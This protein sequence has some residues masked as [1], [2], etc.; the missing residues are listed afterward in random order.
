LGL[1]SSSKKNIY[2]FD[3]WTLQILHLINFAFSF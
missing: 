2:N 1:F 3:H